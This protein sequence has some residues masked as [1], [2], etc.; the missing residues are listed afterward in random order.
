VLPARELRLGDAGTEEGFR[1][2]FISRFPGLKGEAGGTPSCGGGSG[3]LFFSKLPPDNGNGESAARGGSNPKLILSCP[4]SSS[5]PSDPDTRRARR[6]RVI[7]NIRIVRERIKLAPTCHI[8]F[9]LIQ[10]QTRTRSSVTFLAGKI[11]RA[12]R[13]ANASPSLFDTSA[14]ACWPSLSL[15]LSLSLSMHRSPG[16]A[17][18]CARSRLITTTRIFRRKDETGVRQLTR[19]LEHPPSS[20]PPPPHRPTPLGTAGNCDN[21]AIVP[22]NGVRARAQGWFST[23]QGTEWAGQPK[24]YAA[25]QGLCARRTTGPLCGRG[26]RAVESRRTRANR[27][28]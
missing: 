12:Q 3:N 19:Q 2:C 10:Q 7:I 6:L 1:Q 15:S 21:L 5:S 18:R 28:R 9:H 23:R 26:K 4:S 24:I 27:S 16:T 20:P 25:L 14:A 11:L 22:H 8:L 17:S 13:P